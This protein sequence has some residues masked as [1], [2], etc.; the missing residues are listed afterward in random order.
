M[1]RFGGPV[2]RHVV[3]EIPKNAGVLEPVIA[4]YLGDTVDVCEA[5]DTKCAQ[6]GHQNQQQPKDRV[7]PHSYRVRLQPTDPATRGCIRRAGYRFGGLQN[8]LGFTV[9]GGPSAR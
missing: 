1:R 4:N 7:Q 3:A 5:L 2:I 9:H 6:A 8:L